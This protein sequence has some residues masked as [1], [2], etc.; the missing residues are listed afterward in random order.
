MEQEV[1]VKIGSL[2]SDGVHVFRI[3]IFYF[4]YTVG[5]SADLLQIQICRWEADLIASVTRGSRKL[6]C[7]AVHSVFT[8][9]K[10]EFELQLVGRSDICILRFMFRLGFKQGDRKESPVLL[11]VI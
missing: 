11:R 6:F 7:H 1:C 10:K 4:A 3:V 8:E 9:Y 5:L 2:Y